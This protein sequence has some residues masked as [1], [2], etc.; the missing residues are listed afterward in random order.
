MMERAEETVEQQI[1]DI[2]RSG[3][4][5]EGS[6]MLLSL[7]GNTVLTCYLTGYI[8]SLF[9]FNELSTVFYHVACCSLMPKYI[10]CYG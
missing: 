7:E 1:L 6:L 10:H 2:L 8:Q 3:S 9:Q 5:E 4:E